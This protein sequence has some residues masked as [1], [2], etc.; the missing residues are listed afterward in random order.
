MG[1]V[2]TL[3]PP[4]ITTEAQMHGALDILDT[5]LTEETP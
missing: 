4:Q 3:T 2:L 5:Y 1:S